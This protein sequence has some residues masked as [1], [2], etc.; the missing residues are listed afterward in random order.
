MLDIEKYL[1]VEIEDIQDYCIDIEDNFF[2]D[3]HVDVEFM[4]FEKNGRTLY[5]R[6]NG[7]KDRYGPSIHI[8]DYTTMDG[9]SIYKADGYQIGFKLSFTSKNKDNI[10]YILNNKEM[11]EPLIRRLKGKG[12][13]MR[14]FP[15]V[16]L[17]GSSD[18]YYT[19]IYF[20]KENNIKT[21]EQFKS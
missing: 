12:I 16:V 19:V 6:I 5:K 4:I 18:V 2:G 1:G 3:F 13:V 20:Y 14:N 15:E 8:G 7:R 10:T 21:F 17:Q 11:L 9:I